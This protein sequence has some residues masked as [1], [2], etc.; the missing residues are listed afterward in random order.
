VT[1]RTPHTELFTSDSHSQQRRR[2]LHSFTV[3]RPARKTQ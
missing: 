2:L 1:Q 3:H